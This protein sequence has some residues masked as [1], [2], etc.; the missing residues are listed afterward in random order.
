MPSGRG[1]TE[2]SSNQS[3]YPSCIMLSNLFQ[4]HQNFLFSAYQA[5][6]CCGHSCQRAANNVSNPFILSCVISMVY[7]SYSP[8]I[9]TS[10]PT[11]HSLSTQNF[12]CYL[13]AL[14][15]SN[16]PNHASY[17]TSV[18]Y[19]TTIN[20][21]SSRRFGNRLSYVL[22]VKTFPFVFQST[23]PAHQI[24]VCYYEWSSDCVYRAQR[25]LISL[26]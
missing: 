18:S 6:L 11:V 15:P 20:L 16:I 22:C 1:S 24:A 14:D 5:F 9:P 23:Q 4:T 10:K 25:H 8:Y 3:C 7:E 26:R 13:A 17:Y 21:P 12:T 19:S 2:I